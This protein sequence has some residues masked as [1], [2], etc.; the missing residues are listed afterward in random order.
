VALQICTASSART[1]IIQAGGCNLDSWQREISTYAFLE[2][3]FKVLE[4]TLAKVFVDRLILHVFLGQ[5]F[6]R[7]WSQARLTRQKKC[8]ALCKL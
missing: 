8:G 3:T 7:C 4:S 1:D 6:R 5:Y 2:S